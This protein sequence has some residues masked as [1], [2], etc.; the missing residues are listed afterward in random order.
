MNDLAENIINEL[1]LFKIDVK[2][3]RL[4]K[5]EDRAVIIYRWTSDLMRQVILNNRNSGE[6]K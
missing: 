5:A 6:V 3:H 4:D 1:E 2:H